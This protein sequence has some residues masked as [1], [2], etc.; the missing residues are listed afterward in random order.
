MNWYNALL[1]WYW[2]DREIVLCTKGRDKKLHPKESVGC[3]YLSLPCHK[4]VSRVGTS[5]Y[6]PRCLCDAITCPCPCCLLLAQH[7]WCK[8]MTWKSFPYYWPFVL[9][10]Y[11]SSV[12]SAHEGQWCGTFMFF[13]LLAWTIFQ[14]TFMRH[15]FECTIMNSYWVTVL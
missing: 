2:I 8:D 15:H 6:T 14:Q 13:L 4:Q 11:R 3:N 5:N 7:S 9:G 12:V 1:H 10:I